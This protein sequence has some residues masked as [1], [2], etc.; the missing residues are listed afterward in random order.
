MKEPWHPIKIFLQ[1]FLFY[2]NLYTF[3]LEAFVP[4]AFM[5]EATRA[6]LR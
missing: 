2:E 4:S 3:A 1:Y 6:G 5:L